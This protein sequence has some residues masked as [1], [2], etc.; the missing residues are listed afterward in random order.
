MSVKFGSYSL[1][2]S[3][4]KSLAVGGGWVVY[5]EN[6][7]ILSED[8]IGFSDRSSVAKLGTQ[9]EKLEHNLKNWNRIWNAIAHLKKW[10]TT[11]K[12]GTQ[13]EKTEGSLKT[14]TQFEML[15]LIF[16]NWNTTWKIGTQLKN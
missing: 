4:L 7:A 15:E 6:N 11:W 14:E 3:L 8:G 16:Q 12:I 13:L 9:L 10:I 2:R 5:S 1:S